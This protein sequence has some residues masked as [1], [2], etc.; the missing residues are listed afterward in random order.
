[1]SPRYY[2]TPA[3]RTAAFRRLALYPVASS[4]ALAVATLAPG[5]LLP[6]PSRP[7][8]PPLA[9]NAPLWALVSLATACALLWGAT[10]GQ[11][12]NPNAVLAPLHLVTVV[13]E[14]AEL[15]AGLLIRTAVAFPDAPNVVLARLQPAGW[16]I[17][18][19]DGKTV[20]VSDPA[21]LEAALASAGLT[22]EPGDR[23]IALPNTGRQLVQR[24]VP[25][26]VVDGGVPFSHRAAADSVGEAL[27][28]I[29][30]DLATA[31]V[32][33]PPEDSPLVPGLRISVLRALPVVITA[34]DLHL[35]ARTRAATVAALLY[36][37]GVTLGP[38]DRVE[39]SL[40]AAVPAYSSVRV[41]RV[42]EAEVREQSDL[43]F[44]TRFQYDDSLPAGTRVRV[45]AGAAGLAERV[46]L[47][48][49]EDDVEVQRLALSETVLRPA[50]DEVVLAG[51]A[52][53][54]PLPTLPGIPVPPATLPGVPPNLPVR[55]VLTMVATAYDAGPISTGKSPGH[56]AYGITA[57]GM[58]AVYG[59]VA[60][61]PRVI[62]MFTRLYV[63]GYGHAIAADTGGAIKG[64]RID[65]F[66]P[67]YWDAVQYGR[68][69]I[70]VYILE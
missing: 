61:D 5:G 46:S 34:P 57:S 39:P 4:R 51:R 67:N 66:Y 3:S 70:Q 30:I 28:A 14:R 60:V 26:A 1:M 29:G 33:Q 8:A 35:E 50:V 21:R 19:V 37:H 55:R 9:L 27:R 43:P 25:F 68:R 47:A 16:T 64:N 69:T 11:M 17:V 58:R 18:E 56:P 7:S 62:P 53:R 59:V 13:A 15:A 22:L 54:P 45:R 63:P 40:D 6:L 31:D 2:P 20:R 12:V 36:E 10:F 52:P 24:A 32:V 41:V 49:V 65:L 38:L 23:V 48:I 44:R 42:R